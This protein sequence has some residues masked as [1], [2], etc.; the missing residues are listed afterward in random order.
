[1]NAAV[2]SFTDCESQSMHTRVASMRHT[3]CP[4]PGP[5]CA[6]QLARVL[7][8]AFLVLQVLLLLDCVYATSEWLTEHPGPLRMAALISARPL[9]V[10]ISVACACGM[11]CMRCFTRRQSSL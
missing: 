11:L 4:S 3:A 6:A 1:M 5:C 8:G 2:Q 10:R 9:K 7:A